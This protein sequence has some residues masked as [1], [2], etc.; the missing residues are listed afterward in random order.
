VPHKYI[1]DNYFRNTE[2]LIRTVET[3]TSSIIIIGQRA[4]HA[5]RPMRVNLELITRSRE[6]NDRRAR[7]NYRTQRLHHRLFTSR[8]ER[9]LIT[10]SRYLSHLSHMRPLVYTKL[11]ITRILTETRLVLPL[12]DWLFGR[13]SSCNRPASGH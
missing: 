6:V 5:V 13:K 2:Q 1:S 11:S 3:V 7:T 4:R 9:A 10:I 8:R 12:V